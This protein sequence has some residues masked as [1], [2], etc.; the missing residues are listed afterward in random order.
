MSVAQE[1]RTVYEYLTTRVLPASPQD[2]VTYP[3]IEGDTG[4]PMG[5]HGEHIGQVLGMIQQGCARGD[6]PPLASI[7]VPTGDDIPGKGYFT[8]LAKIQLNGNPAGW[9]IDD[10]VDRWLK[11]HAPRGFDKVAERYRYREMVQ[12]HQ[13]NL[14]CHLR[15]HPRVP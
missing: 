8:E 6:L 5:E 4:V 2:V 1:A 3:K 13:R 9:R 15:R 7:V 10:G 14:S 11:G 12:E